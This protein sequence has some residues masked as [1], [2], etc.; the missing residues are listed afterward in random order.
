M[1]GELWTREIEVD[2]VTLDTR[3]GR[4]QEAKPTSKS[5]GVQVVV[6]YFML[7]LLPLDVMVG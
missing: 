5:R 1:A 6:R 4:L 7:T 2:G 3:N